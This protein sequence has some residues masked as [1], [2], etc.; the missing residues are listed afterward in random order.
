VINGVERGVINLARVIR[1]QQQCGVADLKVGSFLI[2]V[3][4]RRSNV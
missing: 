2:T 3:F 1:V 4:C